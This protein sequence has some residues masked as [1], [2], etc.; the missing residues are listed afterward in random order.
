MA[1]KLTIK[2]GNSTVVLPSNLMS[3]FDNVLDKIIPETRKELSQ[4]VDKIQKDAEDNWPVRRRK[5]GSKNPASKNSKGKIY[6]E[7][8]VT[9][10]M[11]IVARVGNDADY[12]WAIKVGARTKIDLPLGRRVSS[13]LLWKPMRK[14][15]NLIINTLADET[16]KLMTK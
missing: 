15:T 9:T 6:T 7:V 4:I 1:R 10:D 14:K 13:E 8:I 3:T 2:S 11:Q 5:D 12:A 16:M